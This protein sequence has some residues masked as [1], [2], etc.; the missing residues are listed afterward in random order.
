[1]EK[2]GSVKKKPSIKQLSFLIFVVFVSQSFSS[3]ITKMLVFDHEHDEE[4]E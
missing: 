3:V 2:R 1:M 4:F